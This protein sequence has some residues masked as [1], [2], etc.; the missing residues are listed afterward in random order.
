MKIA[1]LVIRD[2]NSHVQYATF[3]GVA[4]GRTINFLVVNKIYPAESFL[5]IL[6]GEDRVIPKITSNDRKIFPTSISKSSGYHKRIPQQVPKNLLTLVAILILNWNSLLFVF[7]WQFDPL[8]QNREYHNKTEIDASL[9]LHEYTISCD[10]KLRIC[11]SDRI[12]LVKRLF[13]ANRARRILVS[14][15][16]QHRNM[17]S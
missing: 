15:C 16:L 2:P 13:K 3:V 10:I 12:Y 14:I 1:N 17:G 7:S 4:T 8:I 9:Y 11:Q 6:R 5:D